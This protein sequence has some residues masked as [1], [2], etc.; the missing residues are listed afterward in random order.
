MADTGFDKKL[1][2]KTLP[3][4]PFTFFAPTNDGLDP[5]AVEDNIEVFIGRHKVSGHGRLR[6]EKLNQGNGFRMTIDN[7]NP[8]EFIIFKKRDGKLTAR[9]ENS[10]NISRALIK[11]DILASNGVVHIIDG[12]L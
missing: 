2:N 10:F 1:R 4:A 8:N 3:Y 6:T 11:S 12:V 7:Y 5:N 9:E